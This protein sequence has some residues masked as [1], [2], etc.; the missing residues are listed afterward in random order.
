MIYPLADLAI[1]GAALVPALYLPH[2]DPHDLKLV[3]LDHAVVWLAV[4]FLFIAFSGTYRRVW[5][6]A[7]L[8]EYIILIV[9][10]TSGV[11]VATAASVGITSHLSRLA[12]IEALLFWLFSFVGLVGLRLF[13]RMI[14]DFLPIIIRHQ[15]IEG[16]ERVACLVYGAG[17]SCTLFLKAKASNTANQTSHR[18]VVCLLDDDANL[19]GRTVY[20]HRVLGGIDKLKGAILKYGVQEIVITAF[21]DESILRELEACAVTH[22]V[23]IF[24]WR[25]DI[26]SQQ[27]SDLHFSF[28]RTLGKMTSHLLAATPETVHNAIGCCLELSAKLAGADASCVV[29]F[30]PGKETII[31]TYRW[32][33]RDSRLLLDAAGSLEAKSFPYVLRQLKF[34]KRMAIPE[35]S[36]LPPV[37]REEQVFLEAQ[38]VKSAVVVPL[39][40]SGNLIGFMG[41]YGI[42]SHVIWE[43]SAVDLLQIQADVLALALMC[44]AATLPPDQTPFRASERVAQHV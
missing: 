24:R 38:G 39:G 41:Y 21:L 7:R 11:L 16:V 13:P 28:D 17:H 42:R 9:A 34:K 2:I 25:T 8:S 12:V 32:P 3:L 6:K 35:V 44:M 23:R 1:M 26:R 37:A 36:G 18:I 15:A 43:Q 20:G 27:V 5:S 22:D 40:R 10:F 29:L 31:Q 19:H 4:P 33:I 30:E 14:Q